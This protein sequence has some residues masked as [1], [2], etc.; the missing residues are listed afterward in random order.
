M[1][2]I[3]TKAVLWAN[4]TALMDRDYGGEN[5]S[6]LARDTKIG[7]GTATR[8]KEQQ[9]SVGI[10]TLEK[11]AEFFGIEPW[12]LLAPG[13]GADLY[14]LDESRRLAPVYLDPVATLERL[15]RKREGPA[16]ASPRRKG[17]A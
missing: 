7:P 16:P 4:V 14:E 3:D 8:M 12:Q 11:L 6:R 17:K 13:L 5:L 10:D 1:P 15:R 2:S 9:T